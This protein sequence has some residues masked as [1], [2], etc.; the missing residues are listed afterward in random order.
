MLRDWGRRADGASNGMRWQPLPLLTACLLAL[1][2]ASCTTAGPPSTTASR[3]ASVAFDSIDGPPHGVFRKLVE[4]LND[5]AQVRRLA[6]VA[7]DQPA[8]YRVRGYL[9]AATVGGRTS[10]TWV[11][12]VYDVEQRRVLRITGEEQ[13]SGINRDAWAAADD[14]M[15]RRIARDGLGRLASFVA[16]DV[17]PAASG[18]IQTAMITGDEASTEVFGIFR[19][20]QTEA[21]PAVAETSTQPADVPLPRGRPA[22]IVAA[23]DR[24]ALSAPGR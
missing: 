2:A 12:D 16:A 19:L 4:T 18:E 23:A 11:W 15:M 1:G 14:A 24:L 10:I 22:A 13:A 17:T 5:E 3:G 6:I 8:L 9:A 7:R 21:E 20:L